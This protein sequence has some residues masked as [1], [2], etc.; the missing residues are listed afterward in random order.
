MFK[1]ITIFLIRLYQK[2]WSK[3]TPNRCRFFPS[4]SEYAIQAVETQG[5]L[6]GLFTAIKRIIKCHPFHPG[7]IDLL[8]DTHDKRAC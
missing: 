3:I 5:P 8:G 1:S 4:C 7:G 6:K 2:T